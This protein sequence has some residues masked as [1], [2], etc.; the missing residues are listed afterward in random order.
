MAAA[1]GLGVVTW[2]VGVER[3]RFVLREY[4]LPVLAA[5]AVPLRILH[6]SDF[7]FIPGQHKK[8][9]FVQRLA[10]LRPDLIVLTGDNLGHREAIA[11]VRQMLAPFA[12]VPGVSVFGSND[13]YGP[14]FK[15]PFTYVVGR[16]TPVKRSRDLDEQALRRVLFDELGWVDLTN[17]AA[18]VNAGGRQVRVIGVDDPHIRV[19]RA[20]DALAALAA[21]DGRRAGRGGADSRGAAED[22]RAVPDGAPDADVL[23]LGLV[24]APYRRIL[25]TF[26]ADAGVDVLFAGHT[27]GGQ[28]CLPGGRALLSNCDLPTEQAGGLSAWTAAGRTVP[29]H[30]SRG[31]GTS[32]YAPYR[33]FCPPEASLV[34]L[35]AAGVGA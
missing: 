34:T 5:G 2:A 31:L 29:L 23:T 32:L 12:G 8:S 26:V 11:G 10:E 30:V 28:V 17:T 35:G 24:H 14:V 22:A 15:N 3:R 6:L 19:D 7:H 4:T 27:H 21:L 18:V 16:H 33:T 25:D 9:R 13:Y 1:A 20:E